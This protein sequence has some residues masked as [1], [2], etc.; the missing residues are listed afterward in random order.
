ML[1]KV[2]IQHYCM[3]LFAAIVMCGKIFRGQFSMAMFWPL[4]QTLLKICQKMWCIN[5]TLC[6]VHGFVTQEWAHK[7]RQ[8]DIK[9]GL[10]NWYTVD[11]F[12]LENYPSNLEAYISFAAY[13]LKL[14]DKKVL[15]TWPYCSKYDQ[16]MLF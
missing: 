9:F 15:E 3:L 12:L 16:L 14:K 5:C 2:T 1:W 8:G 4:L 10:K 6:R 11:I 7:N 13:A